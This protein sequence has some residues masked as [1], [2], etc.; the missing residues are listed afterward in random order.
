MQD[1]QRAREILVFK[2]QHL[3]R[4]LLGLPLHRR[5]GNDSDTVIDLY[6]SFHGFDIVE[7][8]H[9]LDF[10]FVVP[11]NLIHRLAGRDIRIEPDKLQSRYLFQLHRASAPGQRMFRVSDQH[12]LIL[13][14][15][16]RLNLPVFQ[17]ESDEPEIYGI[18]QNIFVDQIRAPV[19][20]PHIY[21]REIVQKPFNIGRQFVEP[22]GI[23]RRDA[24]RAADHLLHLLQLG[25]QLFIT[26]QQ[27]LRCLVDRLAFSRELELFLAAINQQGLKM[28]LHRPSLLAYGGLSDTIN[29]RRLRKTLGFDEVGKDFE[30]LNLHKLKGRS[31]SI[32]ASYQRATHYSILMTLKYSDFTR[33]A[34]AVVAQIAAACNLAG[35]NPATVNLLAV[36]KTHGAWAP[37]FAARYGLSR[38]GENRVQEAVDKRPQVEADVCWEL[39]GHLQ[40][41]KARLAAAHFDRIQSVD[42]AKLLRRLNS[43]AAE[44]DRSLA[45]LLQINAGNDPAKFG[46]DLADAPALL[47]TSLELS[48]L[49]VDGLMTIAPLSEDPAV[50]QRTF[51][52]LRELRDNLAEKFGVDLPELSMGMSGDLDFAIAAG[53][54][55]VRVGTA[56]FGQRPPWPPSP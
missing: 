19:L 27:I 41:N 47:E 18:M 37:T 28:L 4:A 11:E 40:S 42:S 14:E 5:L 12:Q 53:S 36:T 48:H 56:L 50:A 39:I 10:D 22:D 9:R 32:N 35:R 25:Q 7:F 23:N 45:I 21:R 13:A 30:I 20:H 55:Q 52:N 17:R 15:R 54:T 26:V 2:P 33:N 51:A 24:N 44:H 29:F 8:H 38:V 31:R 6:R 16:H 49:K 1:R 3:Q 46:A 43:A 34:D